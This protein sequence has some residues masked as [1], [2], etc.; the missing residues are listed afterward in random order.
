MGACSVM[1]NSLGPRGLQPTRLICPWN[2]PG[3]NAG[4]GCHFLLQGIFLTQGWTCVR[5][6]SCISSWSLYHWATWEAQ[7]IWLYS[8][9]KISQTENSNKRAKKMT[10]LLL[11][12]F[13]ANTVKIH[14]PYYTS[15]GLE[16]IVFW[17]IIS[18]GNSM[19]EKLVQG[20]K[21]LLF[22]NRE[23]DPD[24]ELLPSSHSAFTVLLIWSLPSISSYS[25][26]FLPLITDS[27]LLQ[28]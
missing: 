10:S 14:S 12:I 13:K 19:A 23:T 28:L 5:H 27:L 20:K 2:F 11:P 21:I 4:V 9:L 6:I 15:G 1:S 22:W 26:L 16:L 25:R 18:L 8:W 7:N 17:C 3:K 24:T